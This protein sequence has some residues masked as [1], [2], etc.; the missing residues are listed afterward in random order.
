MKKVILLFACLCGLASPL[1]A[2]DDAASPPPPVF[3]GQSWATRSPEAAGL[4]KEKLQSL[5]QLVGGRG[6]V[7]RGGCMVFAWGDQQQSS[8]VASAFKPLL[9]TLL[10]VAVQEGRLKSVDDRV[11]EFEP[12]LKTLHEGKDAAITWRHL[13]SQTS[14]YGLAERPGEAYAYNDYAITLYYDTLMERVFA[15]NGTEVLR[16]RLAGPLQFEDPYTFNAFGPGNRPGRLALSCRDFARFGLLVLRQ[17]RWRGRPLMDGK[18]FV[19]MTNSLVPAGFPLTAGPEADM[20]PRQR[21]MGGT[22]NITP[23]GPGYYSFNWWLNR[24]NHLGQRL[25]ADAPPDAMVASGHGG[26]R[27]L[28][29]IPSLDL[30]VCWNDSRID[31]HDQSPGNPRTKNNQAARWIREAVVEGR[32]APP[33]AGA[34]SRDGK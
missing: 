5:S 15:T 13:A 7:V 1:R 34:P 23:A 4:S 31:D 29:L 26:K 11:A 16:T 2:G 30:I 28:M 32:S 6:C 21:S 14:G 24:T 33:P 12:R 17:G 18:A 8:D 10:F 20:I 9:S 3:P 27:V 25:L 22:R 19:V